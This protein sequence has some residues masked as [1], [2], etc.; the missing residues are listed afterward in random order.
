MSGDFTGTIK[1]FL[2]T[3]AINPYCIVTLATTVA[4]TPKAAPGAAGDVP[5]GV[6]TNLT[7]AS[8]EYAPIALDG[9]GRV[10]VNANSVNIAA[11]D[12][13]K[14]T[15]SAGIGVKANHGDSVCARALE[16]ATADGAIIACEIFPARAAVVK[17][18]GTA[19]TDATASIT[20]TAAQLTTGRRVQ[21]TA[22]YAGAVALAIPGAAS[23]PNGY[24]LYLLKTGSAGAITVTPAAGSIGDAATHASVDA[25]NDYAIYRS[26]G[27][28]NWAIVSSNIA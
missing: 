10:T 8:G 17:V 2:S 7:I 11:G 27:I 14:P 15:G 20:L 18:D 21:L 26:D 9:I 13:I 19:L 12:F 22:S 3:A 24:E 4:D 5:L 25:T 23:V 28:G 1:T 6:N 16:P